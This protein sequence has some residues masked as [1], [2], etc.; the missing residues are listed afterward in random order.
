[1]LQKRGINSRGKEK[2]SEHVELVWTAN[3]GFLL[4][5][6]GVS[7]LI[8][9]AL[10]SRIGNNTYLMDGARIQGQDSLALF[11]CLIF[12]W[13]LASLEIPKQMQVDS[14]IFSIHKIIK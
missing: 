6:W 2:H 9:A 13:L 3:F 8:K 10:G 7:L 4:C 1:M 12:G 11:L 14:G 5:G